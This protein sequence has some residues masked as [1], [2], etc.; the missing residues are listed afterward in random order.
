MMWLV[1]P[2]QY[3]VTSSHPISA[4]LNPPL[5]VNQKTASPEVC[6]GAIEEFLQRL[7]M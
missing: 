1:D 4:S 5:L 6:Q 3:H 2:V 7:A